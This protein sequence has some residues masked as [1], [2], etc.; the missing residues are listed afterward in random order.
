MAGDPVRSELYIHLNMKFD[1][2][3]CI[4]EFLDLDNWH[5]EHS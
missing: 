5:Q 1:H 2:Y 4:S 3:L